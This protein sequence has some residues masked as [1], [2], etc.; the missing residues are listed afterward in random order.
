MIRNVQ[1]IYFPSLATVGYCLRASNGAFGSRITAGVSEIVDGSNHTGIYTATVDESSSPI[2]IRWDT[3]AGTTPTIYAEEDF[4]QSA[5]GLTTDQANT[6]NAIN[7]RM[8]LIGSPNVKYVSPVNQDASAV[9]VQG[10]DYTGAQALQWS[11]TNYAGP[12][13]AGATL[14]CGLMTTKAYNGDAA[15]VEFLQVAGTVTV[16]TETDSSKTVIYSMP[17]TAAQTASLEASP[18]DDQYN[19]V[20]HLRATTAGGIKMTPMIVAMTVKRGIVA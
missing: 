1:F 10:D 15:A 5:G 20:V 16:N 11:T 3:G 4:I 2:A 13:L 18:I 8:N 6:L 17:L 7:A 9:I 14:A 19:W 12:D